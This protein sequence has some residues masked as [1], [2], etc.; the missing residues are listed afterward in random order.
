MSAIVTIEFCESGSMA[1]YRV[2]YGITSD[3][4]KD[5]LAVLAIESFVDGKWL[6]ATDTERGVAAFHDTKL[7]MF[8][9]TAIMTHVATVRV[10]L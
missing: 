8:A 4:A 7:R 6:K 5:P 1:L 10:S 2:R 9:R 3:P